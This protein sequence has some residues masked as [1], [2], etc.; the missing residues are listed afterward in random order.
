MEIFDIGYLARK[1]EIIAKQQA[2]YSP[3]CSVKELD[4]MIGLSNDK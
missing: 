3:K 1:E 2:C 4:S